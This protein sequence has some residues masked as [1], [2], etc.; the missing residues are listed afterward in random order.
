MQLTR[1]T[2]SLISRWRTQR[3]DRRS[4]PRKR[5]IETDVLLVQVESQLSGLRFIYD[6]SWSS[7]DTA[8]KN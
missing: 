4:I 8:S 3:I 2:Y 5:Y 6:C 7:Q 1:I